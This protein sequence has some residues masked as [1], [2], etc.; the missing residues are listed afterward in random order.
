M[1][2]VMDVLRETGYGDLDEDQVAR[3]L[4]AVL[5]RRVPSSAGSAD[6]AFLREHAGVDLHPGAVADAEAW[7]V[8]Q[9]LAETA[10]ALDTPAVA[11]LLGVDRT[12][13]QHLRAAGD[14]VAHRVGRSNRYPTW[15]FADRRPLPGLRPVL[16]ALG[17]GAH[18]SVVTGFFTTPQPELADG[19]GPTAPAAWLAAGHDPAPVVRLATALSSPW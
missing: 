16:A 1:T 11:A 4:K 3:A 17:S 10:Q 7:H 12:R 14:L 19:T 2:S 5:P 13:V 15:Q 9:R 6:D 8:A 18:H